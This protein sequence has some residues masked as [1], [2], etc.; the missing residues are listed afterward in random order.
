M[1][2]RESIWLDMSCW[3]QGLGSDDLGNMSRDCLAGA[4]KGA[5]ELGIP[6]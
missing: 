6:S 1:N 5:K 2:E 4:W 3:L